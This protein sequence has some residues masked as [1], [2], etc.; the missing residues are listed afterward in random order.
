M[1]E[2]KEVSR[3]KKIWDQ[4][5]KA[6]KGD[7]TQQLVENFTAEMTLVAEG[8]C[9]DHGRL[10]KEVEDL[11]GEQDRFAQHWESE[12]GALETGL[13]ESEQQTDRRIDELL[14]RVDALEKHERAVR[15]KKKGGIIP[16]GLMKQLIVLASILAGAWVLVTVLN[17]FK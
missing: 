12:L 1:S 9:D 6:V 8:L 10:R 3:P 15:E 13:R 17:L 16:D 2:E 5:L 11:A 7:S 4:A 14:R